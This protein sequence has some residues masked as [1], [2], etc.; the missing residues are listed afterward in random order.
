MSTTAL[1]LSDVASRAARHARIALP[2][3]SMHNI[4]TAG[5]GR[6]GSDLARDEGFRANV[7]SLLK[8]GVFDGAL[9]VDNTGHGIPDAG[10]MSRAGFDVSIDTSGF[11]QG[12][13][14]NGLNYV[15]F[16]RLGKQVHTY[17]HEIGAGPAASPRGA[18]LAI[19]GHRKLPTPAAGIPAVATDTPI[20][21]L[22]E[23]LLQSPRP[24]GIVR[25]DPLLGQMLL[26]H[27]DAG[28]SVR[29]FNID[30]NFPLHEVRD[31]RAVL[32]DLASDT[33]AAAD[34]EEW[35]GLSGRL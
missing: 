10:V 24:N 4:P 9:I 23:K 30:P 7:D 28:G 34:A 26:R 16:A 22:L 12:T 27:A 33:V 29:V 25:A 21:L 20:V 6:T 35:F 11:P 32:D 19:D 1:Q 31:A 2:P 17:G 14:Y 5:T 18:S 13:L 3:S 8:S 15:N